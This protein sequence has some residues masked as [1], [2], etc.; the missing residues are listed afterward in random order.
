MAVAV[1]GVNEPRAVR[2]ANAGVA[3]NPNVQ[4][5]VARYAERPDHARR[6]VRGR[7]DRRSGLTDVRSS[8]VP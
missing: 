3:A 7:G 1:R 5:R 2:A 8:V 4:V 6:A